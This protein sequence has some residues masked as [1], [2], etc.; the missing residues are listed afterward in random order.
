MEEAG[1]YLLAEIML[2]LMYITM[3]VAVIAV[4]VSATRSFWMDNMKR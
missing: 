1:S 3:A 2:W 4:L